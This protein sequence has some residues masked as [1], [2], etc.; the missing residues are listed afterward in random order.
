MKLE[1]TGKNVKISGAES[2]PAAFQIQNSPIAFAILSSRLYQ[3]K[4]LACIRE[5]SCNAFDAHVDAGKA[6]QP[7]EVHLPT[8]FEPWFSVKDFGTGLEHG[9]YPAESN[10]FKGSGVLDAAG[11]SSRRRSTG[12]SPSSPSSPSRCGRP[13][14]CPPWA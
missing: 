14:I 13:A 9:E 10:Q 6:D 3:D 11:S 4:I 2:A 12:T 1:R 8:S 7:F 5:L